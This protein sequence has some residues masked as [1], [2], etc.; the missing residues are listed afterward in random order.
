MH[1]WVRANGRYVF[2]T[3]GR[4]WQGKGGRLVVRKRAPSPTYSL[5]EHVQVDVI[6]SQQ[7]VACEA[8]ERPL[9]LARDMVRISTVAPIFRSGTVELIDS[10]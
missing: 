3:G 6:E 9:Q 10:P 8:P 1:V 7:V 5:G 4:Q 2:K